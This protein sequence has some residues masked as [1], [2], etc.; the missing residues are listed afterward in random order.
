M[1]NVA[2]ANGVTGNP[3]VL[4]RLLGRRTMSFRD[5]AGRQLS[6]SERSAA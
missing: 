2:G 6:S 1:I 5:V 4:T 3:D